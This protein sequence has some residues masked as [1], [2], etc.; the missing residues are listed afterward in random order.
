[1]VFVGADSYAP[2]GQDGAAGRFPIPAFAVP[3][4]PNTGMG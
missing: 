2:F 1:M 3:P 4:V